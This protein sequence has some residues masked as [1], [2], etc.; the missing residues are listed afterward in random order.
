MAILASIRTGNWSSSSTWGVINDASYLDTRTA[1][2]TITTG[3]LDSASFIPGAITL[4]GICIYL[5]SRAATPSGT[6]TVGLVNV[7]ANTVV[8]SVTTNVSDFPSTGGVGANV[9]GW[10]FFRFSATTTLLGGSTTYSVRLTTSASNQMSAWRSTVNNW[11]RA[12]VTTTNATPTTGDSVIVVGEYTSAG[13][14]NTNTVTMDVTNSATTFSGVSVGLRGVL[15]YG[16][17]PS[18]NY[19]LRIRGGSLILGN[20]STFSIGTSG[21]SIPST[22]TA[23]LEFSASTLGNYF[24][25]YGGTFNAYGSPLTYVGAKL[26]GNVSAATVTTI[27][28]VST[29]WNVNDRILVPTTSTTTTQQDL[30]TITGITGT[31]I[32]HTAYS[33]SHDGDSATLLQAD[34]VNITRNV[35][36]FS[37]SSTNR[38]TNFSSGYVAATPATYNLYYTEMYDMGGTST[39]TAAISMG[40]FTNVIMSGC[41]MYLTVSSNTV[42]Q[43]IVYNSASQGVAGTLNV[44][45]SIFYNGFNGLYYT[46]N[47]SASTIVNN[48]YIIS[49]AQGIYLQSQTGTFSGITIAGNSTR[50]LTVGIA[51]TNVNYGLTLNNCNLY[52]NAVGFVYTGIYTG[53]LTINNSRFWRNATAINNTVGAGVAIAVT[54]FSFVTFNNIYM[55]ANTTQHLGFGVIGKLI[56]NNSFFWGLSTQVAIGLSAAVFGVSDSMIFN[57]CVFGLDY[58]GGTSNFSVANLGTGYANLQYINFNNCLFSG[59]E[60]ANQPGTTAFNPFTYSQYGYISF[61]HNRVSG[62]NRMFTNI[63]NLETDTTITNLTNTSLR[64]RPTSSTLKIKSNTVRV[65]I[66]SGQTCTVSTWVRTS[67]SADLSGQTY[68]GNFPRLIYM[69][70]PLAGNNDETVAA[71]YTNNNLLLFQQNFE[72]AY[73]SSFGTATVSADAG[74]APDGTTSADLITFP[75][76]FNSRRRTSITIA[77]STNYNLS[78][79]FKNSTFTANSNSMSV[80]FTNNASAPNDFNLLMRLNF[81]AQTATYSLTGTLNTGYSGSP[82]GSLTTLPNGW[83]KL[84]VRGATG[85]SASGTTA[86][87]EITNTSLSGSAL[88]WGAQLYTGTSSLSYIPDGT[89]QQLSYTTPTSTAKTTSEFYVDCDGTI[90]WVNVADWNTTTF[91]NSK[92]NSYWANVGQYIEPDFRQPGGSYTFIT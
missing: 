82:T 22:S 46:N 24:Q 13:V 79:Y 19:F 42:Y 32:R 27:T 65:P 17:S 86:S 29:G 51:F 54:K 34:V 66:Q 20:L 72:N 38:T 3:N 10:T 35:K 21:T 58:T 47:I 60:S 73:W 91:N 71:T 16:T 87:Y 53:N 15:T 83:Y 85:T 36:I 62:F 4:S 84:E 74:V 6:L 64:I 52:G 76:G 33:F 5:A 31:T 89:W 9:I 44:Y 48:V 8:A 67:S 28:D 30:L 61:N 56:F 39:T 26:N 68:N 63:G 1:D 25:N 23:T 37:T 18:T 50:A 69:Y 40:S 7:T 43:G 90:G 70:N 11:N 75:S 41:S 81:S 12:L 88:V 59:T 2:T 92:D 77:N 45:D 57:N 49:N 55:Y 80:L 14:S 78:I